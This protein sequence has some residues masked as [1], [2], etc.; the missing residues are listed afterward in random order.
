MSALNSR[1]GKW[2]TILL[3][4]LVLIA[5][6]PTAMPT[7]TSIVAS[8]TR[9]QT[10]TISAAPLAVPSPTATSIA[11]ADLKGRALKV[12]SDTAYPPFESINDKKEIVGFDVDLVNEIC[13]RV[14]CKA[15]FVTADFDALLSAVT[16]QM[17][18]LSASGWTITNERART[19]DFGLPYMPNTQVLLVRNDES[20]IKEPEDLKNTAYSVAVQFGTTNATTVRKIV[21]D[22]AKQLKEFPD[23]VTAVLA[24]LNRQVD[25]VDVNMFAA[26]DLIDQNKGKIKNTG[27]Q[28]GDDFL[29][30]VFRKGDTELKSAFDSG[31]KAIY[32]D[33]TWS[34]LCSNWWKDASLKPDCTGT[35]LPL[36]K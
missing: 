7:P 15:T 19:V 26:S 20:R 10:M 23:I 24:L 9:T 32:Q 27:K 6:Q 25:A 5:C 8:P 36:G 1:Q 28:F 12:G 22:P 29:G 35:A 14:N 13:K 4:L 21:V 18:D 33:G 34:K 16:N 31:L 2:L 30:L 3:V 11:L 17:Y